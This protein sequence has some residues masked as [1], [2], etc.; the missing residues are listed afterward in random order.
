[1][2]VFAN[3]PEVDVPSP[4]DP[5]VRYFGPGVHTIGAGQP[6]TSGQTVY[7]AGGALRLR[8]VHRDRGGVTT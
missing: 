6:I 5:N 2:L 7:V 4:G 3:P 1:M 8:G